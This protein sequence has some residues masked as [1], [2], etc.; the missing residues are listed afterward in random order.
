MNAQRLMALML[1]LVGIALW[2]TPYYGYERAM[3]MAVLAIGAV[4]GGAV[5]LFKSR[6]ASA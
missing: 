4:V 2:M 1:I 6:Q 3:W 5:M